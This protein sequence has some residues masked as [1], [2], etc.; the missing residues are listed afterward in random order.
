M[1]AAPDPPTPEAVVRA[2]LLALERGDVDAAA[3]LLA[4]DVEYVN[5]TLP[6]VHGRVRVERLARLAVRRGLTFRVHVHA[7]AVDGGTVLTDR[8][9]ELR[10]GRVAQRFWV[11]GRFEVRDGRIA[12]WRDS[13]DW[14]DLNVGLLRGLAG[15]VVPAANRRWPG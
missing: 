12:L 8:T 4:E 5:V 10:I 14:L 9:D 7:L 3:A 13:F 6:A 1:A 2:F 15:A 11:Y